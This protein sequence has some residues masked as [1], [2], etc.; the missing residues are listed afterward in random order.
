MVPSSNYTDKSSK[1]HPQV[2]TTETKALGQPPSIAQ[3]KYHTHLQILQNRHVIHQR[4]RVEHIKFSLI[5]HDKR[6]PDENLQ[7]LLQLTIVFRA[8]LE[9]DVGRVVEEIRSFQHAVAW[10]IDDC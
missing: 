5:C 4:Q 10:I 3:S 7:S 6:I 1:I 9:C 2:Q 8:P